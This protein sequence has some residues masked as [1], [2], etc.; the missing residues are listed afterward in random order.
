M[1][2]INIVETAYRGTLEEQDDTILWISHAMKGAG[3]DLDVLLRGNAVN[4]GV[5]GQDA[6]GLSFGAL[7]QAHPPDLARDVTSL[8]AGGVR[9]FVVRQDLEERGIPADSLVSGLEPVDRA[10]L[11]G[12]LEDYD[13]I[14]H[15]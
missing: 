4:C 1:K 8:S 15:W 2:A 5:R 10:G 7:K 12:L 3:A 13:L 9:V 6:S 11:P 14:W